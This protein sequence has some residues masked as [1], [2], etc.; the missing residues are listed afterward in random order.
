MVVE[1]VE[2]DFEAGGVERLDYLLE[3]NDLLAQ[4]AT[5][6][7]AYVRGQSS[8][9][10]DSPNRLERAWLIPSLMRPCS[11]RQ[12]QG[13]GSALTGHTVY[14]NTSIVRRHDLSHQI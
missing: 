7:I 13:K 1:H 3:L 2:D 6:R 11:T 9:P 12:G 4:R 5:A 14:R 8:Q 10:N